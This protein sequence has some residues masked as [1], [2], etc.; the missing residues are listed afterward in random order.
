MGKLQKAEDGTKYQAIT[1][2]GGKTY[3]V[4][5]SGKIKKNASGTKDA[6]GTEYTTNSTGEIT[7]VNDMAV[8]AGEVIGREAEEPIWW[9]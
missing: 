3:L 2:P 8:G 4:N 6:D 7:A 5:T 1:I 9:D